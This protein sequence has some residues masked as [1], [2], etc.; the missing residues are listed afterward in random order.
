[1]AARPS[2]TQ[3]DEPTMPTSRAWLSLSKLFYFL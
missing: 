2:N 1:L 3:R